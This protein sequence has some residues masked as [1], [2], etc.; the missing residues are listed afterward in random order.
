MKRSNKSVDHGAQTHDDPRMMGERELST[1]VD[2]VLVEMPE[3]RYPPG[4]VVTRSRAVLLIVCGYT[5]VFFAGWAL[6]F[7]L[8]AKIGAD[9]ARDQRAEQATQILGVVVATVI[10]VSLYRILRRPVNA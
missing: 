8:E 1:S 6:F 4:V 5:L 2:G 9:A 10:L 7:S 3:V